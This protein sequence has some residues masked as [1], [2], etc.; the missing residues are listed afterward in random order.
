MSAST[1]ERPRPGGRSPP[2]LWALAL[3]LGAGCG[4]A[5]GFLHPDLPPPGQVAECGDGADN[6]GD[7]RADYDQNGNGV[8]DPEDDPGCLSASWDSELN[9]VLPRCADGIDND[10]DHL[11][12]FPDDPGCSSRNDNDEAN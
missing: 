2:L 10:G 1:S 4:P 11:I 7:G 9:V 5:D 6:D 8:V 3:A 12:D